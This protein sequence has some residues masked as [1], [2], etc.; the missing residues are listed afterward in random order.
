MPARTKPRTSLRYDLLAVDLDGTLLNS[1]GEITARNREAIVRARSAGLDVIVCTGRGLVECEH[2]I[3][4]IGQEDA[5]VVAGGAIVACPVRRRTIHR[6]CLDQDL[7]RAS[8]AMLHEHGHAALVLKDALEVGYDYLVVRGRERHPIDPV[9]AWWFEK[10][11]ARVRF[12]DTLDEDEHPGHTVRVGACGPSTRFR[13]VREQIASAFGDRVLVQHFQAVT[14]R[15][16]AQHVD[17]EETLDVFEVFD[18]QANKW[19]ALMQIAGR[20][21]IDP[22][23]ICAVGDE[24]NDEAMVREAGLGVA[25]GNACERV[26]K[27]ADRVA[28]HH[29]EDGVA[30]AIERVLDGSW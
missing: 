9:S 25:M 1:D 3:R 2:A 5:V 12:C 7:V 6:F 19:S 13:A 11:G 15:K 24:I 21:G 23:R 29:D 27:V 22:A 30:Y 16:Y 18:A 17:E 8:T 10:M 26:R 20:R 14:S 4:T 28:P